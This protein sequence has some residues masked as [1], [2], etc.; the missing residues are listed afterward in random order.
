[1]MNR[2]KS[3]LS[4]LGIPLLGL[5]ALLLAGLQQPR[6]LAQTQTAETT[7]L[8]APNPRVD[9]VMATMLRQEARLVS[10]RRGARGAQAIASYNLI[11]AECTPEVFQQ[12]GLP[13]RM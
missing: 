10:R 1:M 5:G 3:F 8:L 11:A 9:G 12:T 4:T 7:Y 2:T 6:P 13:P